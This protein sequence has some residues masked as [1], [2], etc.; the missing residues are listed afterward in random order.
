MIK[1]F[2]KETQQIVNDE[3][4][5]IRVESTE[6]YA[7]PNAKIEGISNVSDT[8]IDKSLNNP[9]INQEVGGDNIEVSV[10]NIPNQTGQESLKD[11]ASSNVPNI[12]SSDDDNIYTAFG[13]SQYGTFG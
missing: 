10:N 6:A 5:R 7:D 8:K 3:K 12:K 11:G 1:E 13:Q 2:R 9:N 4:K